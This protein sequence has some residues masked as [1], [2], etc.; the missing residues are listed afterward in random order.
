M[1]IHI[2]SDHAGFELKEQLKVHLEKCGYTIQ[3]H[4][5]FS[6][7]RADYPDYAHA[8]A[9]G[10]ASN[11]EL[12]ILVCGSGNGVCI[13][14][15]KHKGIRAALAWNT[16]VAILARQHNDANILCLPARFVAATEAMDMA[17]AFLTSSFEGG[18][19]QQRIDKIEVQ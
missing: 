9:Y 6:M 18:R 2:G 19:H 1:K 16:E 14:A 8:V 10:V 13:A 15:N 12:G 3:D 17:D 5:T 11:D 7:D 4:G